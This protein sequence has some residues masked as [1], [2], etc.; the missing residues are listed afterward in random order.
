MTRR[1]SARRGASIIEF[2]FVAFL[3]LVTI[4]ASFE[5]DRMIL[6]Y[7]TVADSARAGVRYAIVHGSTR[8]STGDPASG[9][10]NYTMVVTVVKN[11]AAAGTIDTTALTVTA[12]YPSGN[13]PGSPVTVSV[14]YP[15][16]PLFILPLQVNLS[17]TTKGVIVF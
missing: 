12:A 10:S 6:V 3:L 1:R 2:T 15:Y 7:T 16:T 4:F 8:T 9:P 17:S 14:S 5:F 13:S 11:Y